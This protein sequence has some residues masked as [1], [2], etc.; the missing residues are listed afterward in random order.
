MDGI[1]LRTR[2][3]CFV[4]LKSP[5]DIISLLETSLRFLV[6]DDTLPFYPCFFIL[7][8]MDHMRH[9]H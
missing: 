6:R 3:D 7:P 5:I 8:R 4:G 1:G 2:R 9:Y